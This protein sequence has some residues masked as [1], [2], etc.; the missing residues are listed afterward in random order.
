MR[1]LRR[2]RIQKLPFHVGFPLAKNAIFRNMKHI[3]L[4]L[5]FGL[6][7]IYVKGQNQLC[8]STF[9]YTLNKPTYPDGQG[10]IIWIDEAH[11]NFHTREGRFCGFARVLEADGYQVESLSTSFDQT[12]FS[13]C[14]VL[15]I[16]N[17][18]DE[19]TALRGWRLPN[20]SA[21]SSAEITALQRWVS[22]GGSLMLIADHMPFPGCNAELA[23]AFGFS[24]S[25][26]YAVQ[27]GSNQPASVFSKENNSLLPHLI[28][29]DIPQVASFTGQAFRLPEGAEPLM[30]FD[31]D[32]VMVLSSRAGQPDRNAD[33]SFSI[34]GWS[35]GAVMAYG[36]GR[37]AVFGEAAMFTSQSIRGQ[38]GNM[39]RFGMNHPAA[40][41]NPQF[42]RN[43]LD[44]LTGGIGWDVSAETVAA[45][46][47]QNF[48][49]ETAMRSGDMQSVADFYLDDAIVSSPGG[50]L[51]KGRE[52]VDAYWEGFEGID[53]RLD[54]IALAPS[55]EVLQ[56]T[57]AYQQLAKSFPDWKED[58]PSRE[59]GHLVYQLGKS[60]LTYTGRGQKRISVVDFLLIWEKQND[61]T[62]K[63]LVDTYR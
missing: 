40:T 32:Y 10:P 38:N 26:G 58:L 13:P 36:Q 16:A 17:A 35:Q 22:G 49:M 5:I 46:C 30:V 7:L 9:Q 20:R 24:F 61:G 12:D 60:H 2:N 50:L 23:A 51:A 43:T 37:V 42:L 29:A 41:H 47:Q 18:L 3:F 25:N 33:P 54:V 31:E 19:A 56:Q 14:D 39:F 55:L 8:D 11:H 4:F 15:V 59:L 53:W 52:Q 6:C 27:T 57:T 63:I 28:T 62:Y 1:F 44:W 48:G 45:V 34:E 21:F